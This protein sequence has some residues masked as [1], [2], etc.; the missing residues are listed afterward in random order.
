MQNFSKN[1]ISNFYGEVQSNLNKKTSQ[2]TRL[3]LIKKYYGQNYFKKKKILDVGGGINPILNGKNIYIVDFKIQKKIKKIFK[4]KVFE[5]DI[6]TKS[7][8]TKFDI[9]FLM[10]TLEHFKY[11]A[12]ALKNIR[13]S[14]KEKGRLFLEIP[15]FEFYTKKNAFYGIFHQHLSLF[16]MKH[17]VNF[18]N[19]SEMQVE[20][21]FFKK[22]AIFCS[23]RK[24]ENKQSVIKYIDN[25]K[26]INQ[27]KKN[28]KKTRFRISNFL[29][30]NV[31]DIYGAGGSMV[32]ALAPINKKKQNINNVFDNDPVKWNK[33]L[34]GT[35]KIIQSNKKKILKNNIFSLSTYNLKKKN[36]LNIH[37][38]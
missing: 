15:N 17:L 16:T 2:N 24:K 6:E 36:N 14:L 3:K 29:K 37:K 33:L 5:I 9:I 11:P 27:F 13:K 18:L 34:P 30:N 12:K 35:K 10:H 26:L 22:D 25:I 20:K 21:I 4:K 19:L 38:L 8:N 7:I 1:K 28:Y 23:I 32:L 31:F